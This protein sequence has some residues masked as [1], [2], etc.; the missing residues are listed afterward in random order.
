[1]LTAPTTGGSRRAFE[2]VIL[3]LPCRPGRKRISGLGKSLKYRQTWE[4]RTKLDGSALL[5]RP[6]THGVQCNY[7][8]PQVKVSIRIRAGGNRDAD[9]ASLVR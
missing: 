1:M 5:S 9:H 4:G 6:D 2:M 3:S 8:L 7:C